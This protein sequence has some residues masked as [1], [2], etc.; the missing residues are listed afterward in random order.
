VTNFFRDPESF[1]TLKKILLE[2]VKSKP[3]NGQIRIWVPGCYTGEE[4]YSIAIL[5]RECM[6]EAKKYLNVQIFA[7]DIDTTAIEKARI[8]SFSGIASDV[9]K[10]RLN[11]FFTSE[12]NLY[13]IRKEIREML[14]FAPQ[15]II[16]DP[17]F[18]K[19]DLIS[20]RNLLIYLNAE[21]QKKIIPV[22]HYSLVPNGIL[23]LGS[24]ET[25]G[26]FVDLFSL[27]DKKWKIYKRRESMY[28]AQPL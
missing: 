25:I 15:S 10:E 17:P 4:A 6:N 12:G 22:F 8:G 11:R 5:L 18:T 7:T 3:D 19:L 9:S 21:L 2:L 26:E 16:K 27:V 23:F 28:S 14:I 13:H 1:E 20:C 24:S